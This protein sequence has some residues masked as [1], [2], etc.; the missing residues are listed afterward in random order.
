[1]YPENPVN[2]VKNAV[3][4]AQTNAM[5]SAS[6]QN[7]EQLIATFAASKRPKERKWML[8]QLRRLPVEQVMPPLASAFQKV[9][10]KGAFFRLACLLAEYGTEEAAA[11]LIRHARTSKRFPRLI[12]RALARCSHPAALGAI[13]DILK[14]GRTEQA[15]TAAAVLGQIRALRV[16]EPLCRAVKDRPEISDIALRSLRMTGRPANL[17]RLVLKEATYSPSDRLRVLR[18]LAVM[19]VYVFP[20]SF[21]PFNGERWLEREAA[22]LNSPV[23]AAAKEAAELMRHQR[24]LLRPAS[25]QPDAVLLRPA[26]QSGGEDGNLLRASDSELQESKQ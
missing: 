11:E 18:A 5:N 13:I 21:A 20:L 8:Q 6:T 24:L 19:P 1:V 10:E 7:T 26:S 9:K 22:S 14:T 12:V 4:A 23:R 25:A 3:P 2:P 16:V 17:A 15:G